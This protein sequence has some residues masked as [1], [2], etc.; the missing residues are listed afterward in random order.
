MSQKI[1]NLH[2][3][4]SEREKAL[5]VQASVARNMSVS[6]FILQTT[7]PV[8]EEIVKKD[9]G[10]IQTLFRLEQAAWEEFNRLL[11]APTRDIPELRKLL[12]SK[13]PWEL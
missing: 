4:A 6:Q 13:A 5:L 11:D 9:G 7:L 10:Q 2:V 3:R 8:A 1:E 12:A